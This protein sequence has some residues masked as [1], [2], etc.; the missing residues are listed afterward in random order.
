M[1]TPQSRCLWLYCGIK[2]PNLGFY[3]ETEA[4]HVCTRA[5][6]NVELVIFDDGEVVWFQ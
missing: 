4:R 1:S 5:L 6:V 3:D 2:A